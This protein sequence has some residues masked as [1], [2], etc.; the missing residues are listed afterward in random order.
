MAKTSIDWTE[1][2]WNPVTGC[3]K[4]SEGCRN[5]YA[6]HMS[7]RLAGRS[8][9]PMDDPFRVTLHPEKLDKLW[10]WK[11]SRRIFVNS[12]S[13]LFHPDIPFE[14]LGRVFGTMHS[15]RQHTFMVLTKR[16]ER[17]KKFIQWYKNDWLAGF[18][19]AWPREYHHVWL[20]VS[21]E[22]QATADERIPLLLQTPA[23]VRFISAEPLLGSVDLTKITMPAEFQSPH[24]FL[25]SLTGFHFDALKDNGDY[26]YQSRNHIDWVIVGGESGPSARPCHPQNYWNPRKGLPASFAR[27]V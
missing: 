2:V 8:G 19:S 15:Y 5:C 20:G 26:M 13:D 1:Y 7:K 18:E 4:V 27:E 3:T 17:M 21:V 10:K 25:P 24:T 23:A 6:E 11:K 12:M 22:N 9:Y 16:P 14:F